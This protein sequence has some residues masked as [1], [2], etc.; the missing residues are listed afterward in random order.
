MDQPSFEGLLDSN[1]ANL[2]YDEQPL[3]IGISELLHDYVHLI[4]SRYRNSNPYHNFEHSAHVIMSVTSFL[5]RIISMPQPLFVSDEGADDESSTENHK[6][7]IHI[8]NIFND[9]ITTFACLL[10]GLIHD[11][12][13]D[14][15]PT[16]QPLANQ[17]NRQASQEQ[18]A[19]EVAWSMLLQPNFMLLRQA[20]FGIDQLDDNPNSSDLNRF[21][22][23]F[24]RAAS[25]TES[26]LHNRNAQRYR[27]VSDTSMSLRDQSQSERAAMA[28]RFVSPTDRAMTIIEYMMQISDIGH[29]IQQWP[30]Y[31]KWNER[32]FHEYLNCH[33]VTLKHR[34][35]SIGCSTHHA[36]QASASAQ[37]A[38]PSTFWCDNE[39]QYMKHYVLPLSEKIREELDYLSYLGPRTNVACPMDGTTPQPQL[40]KNQK[41]NAEFTV[42]VIKLRNEWTLHGPT[43]IDEMVVKYMQHHKQGNSTKHH[44]HH[45]T[46]PVARSNPTTTAVVTTMDVLSLSHKSDHHKSHDNPFECS[47]HNPTTKRMSIQ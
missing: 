27:N 23:I 29:M 12:D 7:A 28:A 35:S 37:Q 14:G 30:I 19:I 6:T 22:Y 15:I 24:V 46:K 26:T 4:A 45:K 5:N 17:L 44:T 40:Q 18:N 8:R 3:D 33:N 41:C 9:P 31:M 25:A 10:A 20:I 36:K 47:R 32:L 38:H 11:V 39:L 13:H 43:I 21:R 34:R 16:K 2:T 42:A 1:N